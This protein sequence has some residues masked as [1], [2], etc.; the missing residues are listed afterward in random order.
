MMYKKLLAI[1]L[2]FLVGYSLPN[3]FSL[4]KK[5]EFAQELQDPLLFECRLINNRC[6]NGGLALRI[7]KGEFS[8]LQRTTFTLAINNTPITTPVLISSDDGQFGTLLGQ[9]SKESPSMVEVLL[10]YCGN[11][12]MKMIVVDKSSNTGLLVTL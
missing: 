3:L 4:D 9:M 12:I 11:K 7:H 2:L 1:V 5:M 8:T 6:E 10:P